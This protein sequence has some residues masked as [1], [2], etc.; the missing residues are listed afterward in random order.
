M[1]K[2]RPNVMIPYSVGKEGARLDFF[3]STC[4]GRARAFTPTSVFAPKKMSNFGFFRPDD[5]TATLK[6]ASYSC[7][8]RG[9]PDVL[10]L[11]LKGASARG[12]LRSCGAL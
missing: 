9:L 10:F 7:N 4:D 6:F 2:N 5:G 1:S 11:T 3:P 8:I 12:D